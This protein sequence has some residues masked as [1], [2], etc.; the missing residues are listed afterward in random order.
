MF[1]TH[2]GARMD[3]GVSACPSCGQAVLYP[4]VPSTEQRLARHLQL[5]GVLWIA[6][7]AFRLL[8]AGVCLILGMFVF[9]A[10]RFPSEVPN[11][12]PPLMALIGGFL[13]VTA[14]AGFAGGWGL[15]QRLPWA[16]VL[17]LILAFVSLLDLPFGTAL[18]VYTLWVL[19]PSEAE[20]EY[21]RMAQTG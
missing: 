21:R 7:S 13:L 11:F 10:I 19:L 18:G 20:A 15:M 16:R 4:V 3:Q 1:C 2:C 6:Y 12:L 5:L 17:L 9:G 8:G 14:V